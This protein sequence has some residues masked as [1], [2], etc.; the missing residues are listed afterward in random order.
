MTAVF[1]PIADGR[2]Y[3][4]VIVD[5]GRDGSAAFT[6]CT[7]EDGAWLPLRVARTTQQRATAAQVTELLDQG[8]ARHPSPNPD[9]AVSRA[10]PLR[11][12]HRARSFYFLGG[13][14]AA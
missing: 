12:R 10:L 6:A 13:P 2:T 3:P 4:M 11:N 1:P 5:T 14:D 9:S 8:Y 7:L